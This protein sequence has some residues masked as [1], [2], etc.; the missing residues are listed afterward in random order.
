[1][2]TVHWGFADISQDTQSQ[3]QCRFCSWPESMGN[4]IADF[5][6]AAQRIACNASNAI[7]FS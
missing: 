6:R 5:P 7:A 2:G 4:P 1:M 3:I